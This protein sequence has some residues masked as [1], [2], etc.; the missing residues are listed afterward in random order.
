MIAMSFFPGRDLH[1]RRFIDAFDHHRRP[2][3]KH[4]RTAGA[5][6]DHVDHDLRIEPG[7][8]RQ[9]HRLGGGDVVNRDQM[10]GDELHAAAV[11][12]R[13]EIGALFGK[14]G[15]Q[16]RAPRNRSAVAAGIDHEITLPCLRAGTAQRTVE[17]NVT[18]FRQDIFEAKLVG[19]GK[20][21]EFDHDPRRLAGMGDGARDIL[22]GC[23][24]GKAGQ[25]DRRVARD[26]YDVGGDRDIRQR[27]LRAPRRV[28]VVADSP[29]SALDQVAGDRPSHDA[30]PDDSDNL[31]HGFVPAGWTAVAK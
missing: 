7:A 5:G 26:L 30:E 14:I 2:H 13:A 23:G 10:V 27:H 20:R 25:D 8:L 29:P 3:L 24:T 6:T 16:P 22:D 9:G 21:A 15:E 1:G 12:E 28:K 17:R 19:D 11:A 4:P 31:A 18:C